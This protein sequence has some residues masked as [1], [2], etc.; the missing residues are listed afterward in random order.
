MNKIPKHKKRDTMKGSMQINKENKQK[1]D[2][3][4]KASCDMMLSNLN[5]RLLLS[6]TKA[7]QS[8]WSTKCDIF[9]FT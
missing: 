8:R 6:C 2:N 4:N 1:T 9:T 3:K 7:A 5:V